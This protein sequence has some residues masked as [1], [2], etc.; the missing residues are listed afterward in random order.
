MTSETVSFDLFVR[1]RLLQIMDALERAGGTPI[2]VR[3][4][5][6]FAYFVNVLSP[7]W[8]VEPL[9]GSVLKERAGPYFPLLQREIDRCIGDG[10]LVVERIGPVVRE[11]GQSRID[12]SFRLAADRARPVIDRISALPDETQICAFLIELAF[13]FL[14]IEADRRDDAALVDAAWS[15]PAVAEDRVVDFAEWVASTYENPAWNAAQRF[16][17]FAP[18]GVTLSRAEKLVMYMRLLKR[19]AYG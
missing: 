15:D 7:L 13:S 12:A 19:R 1:G 14:E 10:L 17:E 3:D 11:D 18:K 6:A 8:E 9:E 4:L 16:Q 2:G 5:H